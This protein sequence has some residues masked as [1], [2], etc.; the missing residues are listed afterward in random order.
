MDKEAKFTQNFRGKLRG[1]ILI[2]TI[3]YANSQGKL[4]EFLLRAYYT[5]AKIRW[6]VDDLQGPFVKIE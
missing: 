2:N 1:L 5:A 4:G 3:V 6:T